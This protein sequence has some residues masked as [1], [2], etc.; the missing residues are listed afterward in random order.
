M[1]PKWFFQL[2]DLIGL[3][4]AFAAAHLLL[5]LVGP[6]LN[7]D[8]T[9]LYETSSSLLLVLALPLWLLM[10]DWGGMY[11]DPVHQSYWEIMRGLLKVSVVALGLLALV[12]FGIKEQGAS[13]LFVFSFG[14]VS[15]GVLGVIRVAEKQYYT[16]RHRAGYYLRRP[17]VVGLPEN[18]DHVR[19]LIQRSG[20][21]YDFV[22]HPFPL[23]P[24]VANGNEQAWSTE[25]RS[26][27]TREPV[28][29]V[30]V[31]LN[32]LWESY[33]QSITEI[34]R[35][36]G[37]PIRL[38]SQSMLRY[39]VLSSSPWASYSE[40][41]LGLPSL[42][43]LRTEPK[44][45][46]DFGKRL[47][48]MVVAAVLLLVL[49]PLLLVIAAAVKLSSPGPI[50]Y[51]WRVLGQN[52]REFV[53]YK[54]RTMV[55]NADE[56]KQALLK[57]NEMK[58]PAFKM[59]N[60]PRVTRVG[61]FLRRYSLDELPQLWSVLKGDMSLVGPRPPLRNEF[62][63]FEFWQARKLS[64]KP[65]ITCLWQIGGRNQIN[66]FA[67]WVRLDLEYIDHRSL[68]LD[69]KILARTAW[70]VFAGTGH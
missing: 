56:L 60:D 30:I 59:K 62:E 53:G 26:V 49:S 57:Y 42:L 2:V 32:P 63:R 35:D 1:S 39:L 38:I 40:P 43:L 65:G 11:A 68:G 25:L 34:C 31:I 28:G 64:V 3:A 9:Q 21:A 33:L 13:R 5:P 37:Q 6:L 66:D 29:E 14:V 69:L 46:Y 24:S 47:L 54:F 27:L 4:A 10:L 51:R 58:G 41:F 12:V 45:L 23:P 48:D 44:P 17:L 67:E 20:R 36:L 7:P 70:A 50:F 55:A 61:R 16:A 52:N 18:I 15:L 19:Q 22:I 8:F